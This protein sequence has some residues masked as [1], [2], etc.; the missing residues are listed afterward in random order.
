MGRRPRLAEELG[1]EGPSGLTSVLRSLTAEL[2][3]LL[4]IFLPWL[5]ARRGQPPHTVMSASLKAVLEKMPRSMSEW[6]PQWVE[7]MERGGV[8]GQRHSDERADWEG[9]RV[10]RFSDQQ[11]SPITNLR[12]KSFPRGSSGEGATGTE[13]N[14]PGRQ[15]ASEAGSSPRAVERL[16]R[17]RSLVPGCGR[18]APAFRKL[19]SFIPGLTNSGGGLTETISPRALVA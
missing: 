14:P 13:I 4:P 3:L 19:G 15:G 18:E 2:S 12:K 10:C 1:S 7:K 5:G 8:G 17:N 11:A 9:R 6:L 16:V